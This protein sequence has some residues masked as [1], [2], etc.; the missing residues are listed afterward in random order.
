MNEELALVLRRCY[1][2]VVRYED[3]LALDTHDATAA[4]AGKVIV[5]GARA[6]A[7][8]AGQGIWPIVRENDGTIAL[9]LINL[10]GLESPE[11]NGS[12]PIDPP[13]R[14]N[15]MLR[16]YT[17]RSPER[18]WWATPDDD[19]LAARVLDFD[20]EED[21]GGTYVTFRVPWLSWWDLIVLE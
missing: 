10:L 8:Q 3:V 12:L 20:T 7:G 21:E 9:S 15:L 2:F 6:D 4:Y 16:F 14:E 11:W 5:D 18:I 13:V 1:D 17:D 19:N